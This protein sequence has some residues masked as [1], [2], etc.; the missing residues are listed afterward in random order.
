MT[1]IYQTNHKT[2]GL[3]IHIPFCQSRCIYCGFYSTTMTDMQDAYVDA[4]I[5][6]LHARRNYTG[7]DFSTVY[8][9]GGTPS[10]LSDHNIIKLA[11][12][13]HEVAGDNIKEFTVE[14]NPDDV[15]SRTSPTLLTDT[16]ALSGVSRVSMGVQTFSSSRLNFLRRRNK[17]EDALK[18]VS[19]LRRS[20]IN[21]IS[22]DLMFGFPEET[23]DEWIDD[24]KA[25]I[26]LD[27]DHISAYSLMYEEGTKLYSL[28]SQGKIKQI[29]EDLSVDMYNVLIDLLN[30]HG[31]EQYEISNFARNGRY[32]IHN[33]NYWNTTPYLGIGAAAHSYNGVSRQ[34]NVSDLRKYIA[35]KFEEEDE[36]LEEIEITSEET[37][38]NDL[39]T[40]ALRTKT[41]ISLSN[42]CDSYDLSEKFMNYLMS[43]SEK[44]ISNGLLVMDNNNLHLTRKGLYVSDDVMSELIYL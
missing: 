21:N 24:I 7:R 25:A 13:I 17:P 30:E 3:Y 20:G 9:G 23:L 6:E 19:M 43:N 35:C 41:G 1:S 36:A 2:S 4:L 32:S 34:W 44:L 14:C 38:Y 29:S 22:I 18:A 31:Y 12:A 15:V 37:R 42:F 27:V 33:S 40:T 39:I 11:E 8:I 28:L 16:L 10:T 26:S 5:R